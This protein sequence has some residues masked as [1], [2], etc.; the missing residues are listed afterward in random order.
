MGL[1]TIPKT[2]E[3]PWNKTNVFKGVFQCLPGV[4]AIES[5]VS[6]RTFPIKDLSGPYTEL[7]ERAMGIEPT[8]EAWEACSKTLK[9]WIWR[10]FCNFR[11]A[12]IGK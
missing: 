3:H 8:S 9:R 7:L 2:L 10:H 11:K 5:S 4:K 6:V 1:G 12:L